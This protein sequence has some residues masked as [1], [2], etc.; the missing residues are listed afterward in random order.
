MKNLAPEPQYFGLAELADML[1]ETG[2]FEGDFQK[3]FGELLS[4]GKVES[5]DMGTKRRSRFVP[6]DA[7]RNKGERLRKLSI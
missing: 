1:E 2:W 7:D 3:A 6:F 4:E 5:L